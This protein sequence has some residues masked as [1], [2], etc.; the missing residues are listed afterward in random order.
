MGWRRSRQWDMSPTSAG[1]APCSQSTTSSRR[2]VSPILVMLT[3]L[4]WLSPK[5]ELD[6]G[7]PWLLPRGAGSVHPVEVLGSQSPHSEPERDL[8]PAA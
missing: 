6:L 8:G 1:P 3:D 4:L 2:S 5:H 7:E